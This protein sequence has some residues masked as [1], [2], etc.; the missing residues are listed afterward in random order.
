M[1]ED[2]REDSAHTHREPKSHPGDRQACCHDCARRRPALR[3]AGTPSKRLP[4]KS[5]LN[6]VV[7]AGSSMVADTTRYYT[8]LHWIL[9]DESPAPGSTL[10][11]PAAIPAFNLFLTTTFD[12]LLERALNEARFGDAEGT[13][14]S[15]FWPERSQKDLPAHINFR[16][17]SRSEVA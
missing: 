5:T 11:H 9:C 1:D 10:R 3:M 4:D 12:G 2:F 8:R 16:F 6:Q 14:V 13:K 17:L 7:I 15:A